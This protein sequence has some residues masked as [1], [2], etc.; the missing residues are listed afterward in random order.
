LRILLVEDEPDSVEDLKIDLESKNYECRICEFVEVEDQLA[1]FRP[2]IVVLD[3]LDTQDRPVGGDA[4]TYIWEH[5]FRPVVV[6]SADPD[7]VATTDHPLV[8][9]VR[10]GAGSEREAAASVDRLRRHAEVLGRVESEAESRVRDAMRRVVPKVVD[11]SDDNDLLTRVVRRHVAAGL[12]EERD[13]E[14]APWEQYLYPAWGEDVLTGDVLRCNKEYSESPADYRIVLTPSCDMVTA[15]NRIAKVTGVLVACCS[16]SRA[17]IEAL[18]KSVATKQSKLKDAIRSALHTGFCNATV[19]IPGLKGVLPEMSANMRSLEVI[20]LANIGDDRPFVR[21]ASVDSPFRELLTWAFLQTVGRPGLPDR[22]V[23]VWTDAVI[24]K[25]QR[26][27][28]GDES[29]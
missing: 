3:I 28:A 17:L 1:D 23:A 11:I 15:G 14:L 19:P 2:G 13:A 4:Y 26:E 18:G 22:D 29:T 10:K 12:D 8:H 9:K 24:E 5:R 7:R 6:Y 16:E 21:V 20:P 25:A 27:A